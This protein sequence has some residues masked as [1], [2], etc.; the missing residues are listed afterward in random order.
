[1]KILHLLAT[2]TFTSISVRGANNF[3]GFTLSNG[4]TGTATYT[5]RTQDQVSGAFQVVVYTNLRVS[6]GMQ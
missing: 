6:S 4:A 2:L 5:C 3:A 1:M